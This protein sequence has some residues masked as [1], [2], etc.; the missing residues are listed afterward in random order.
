MTATLHYIYDPLCGWC[1]GAEPL[2]RAAQE[3]AGLG[4]ELHAGALFP[5]PTQLAPEMRRYIQ[6]ADRRVGE[7]SGQPYGDAYLNGLLLDPTLVLDSP[8]TI[9]AVLAAQALDP[10]KALPMLRAIQH[11]HWEH[12]RRVV[13]REVLLDLAADCGF[14]RVEFAAALDRA[15]AD[16]HIART[17]QLME[18]VGAGGFPTFV[19]QVDDR[20]LPVPHQRFAGSPADFRRWLESQIAQSAERRVH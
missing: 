16:E 13:E 18:H 15:P 14:D 5:Q 3:A 17:R 1:Y 20:L 4:L 12:G 11:A 7:I 6:Q 9:A 19:L 10:A 8:P 2:V